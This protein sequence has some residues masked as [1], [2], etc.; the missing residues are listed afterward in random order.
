MKLI[1]ETIRQSAASK[2]QCSNSL[3]L[4]R[5]RSMKGQS[6]MLSVITKEP[7]FVRQLRKEM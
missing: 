5:A 6:I 3:S 4:C 2:T 7:N 1:A